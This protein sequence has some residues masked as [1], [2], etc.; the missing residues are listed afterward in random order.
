VKLS[1]LAGF[2]PH[3][4][5]PAEMRA[6]QTRLGNACANPFAEDFVFEVSE[7]LEQPSHG[8]PGRCCQIQR[9]GERY[10]T[11]AQLR[12]IFQGDDQVGE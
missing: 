10:E 11:N 4:D 8:A 12:Q 1:D 5:R 7:D 2:F 9:F 3:R 6:L